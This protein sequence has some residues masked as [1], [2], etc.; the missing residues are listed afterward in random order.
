MATMEHVC[1]VVRFMAICG[2]RRGRMRRPNGPVV[3][4]CGG[5]VQAPQALMTLIEYSSGFIWAAGMM[6]SLIHRS[7]ALFVK[8]IASSQS[9]S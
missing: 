5:M 4:R 7:K 8:L 3:Y 2:V 6:T 9:P 1:S